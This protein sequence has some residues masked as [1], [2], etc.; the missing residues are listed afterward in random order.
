MKFLPDKEINLGARDLLGAKPYVTTLSTIIENSETPFTIGL[1][2]GWGVGK[3]S[4]IKTIQDEYNNHND[5]EI[6]VFTYDAW[7]YSN[8]SFR[9][10]F[11]FEIKE[12]FKMDISDSFR[13]FYENRSEEIDHKLA[14][15]K[16][17][18]WW[19][20]TLFPLLLF[21]VLLFP[22]QTDLKIITSII[23]IV[24]TIV[25]TLLRE[26]FVQYKVTVSKQKV[27]AP[28]QFEKIFS[29]IIEKITNKPKDKWE[30]IKGFLEKRKKKIKKLV[31]VIDN[32]DR[33]HK[34]LAFELLL[35]IKNFLEQKGVVFIIP[36]DEEE[37]K[38]HIKK[39]G[40]N[41]NEFLRKLFNTTISIKHISEG[42]LFD[43]AKKLN[44]KYNLKFP[45]DVI[46][47]VAQQFSK[48]PR[49]IIQ[50]LN[51]LQ[52][53][54]LLSKN[55]ESENLIPKGSISENIPF[56]TKLL[57]M[58]EEWPNLYFLF[59]TKP[60]ILNNIC[61]NIKKNENDFNIDGYNL[62]VEQRNFLRRTNHI[63][64]NHVNYELFF[65]NKDLYK[66]IPD[67]TSKLIESNDYE[68]IIKQLGLG[69]INFD[70]LIELIDKKLEIALERE[71]LNT[72]VVNI[73][74]LIMSLS[75]NKNYKQLTKQYLYNNGK[76]LGS[77]KNII[78]S[79]SIENPIENIDNITILNFIKEYDDLS[80][81]IFDYLI[82]KLRKRNNNEQEI[83][84]FVEIFK[85]EP[86]KLKKIASKFS[87]LVIK[88]DSFI[89][90]LKHILNRKSSMKSLVT[91]DLINN[92][93]S[94][95]KENDDV[96]LALKTPLIVKYHEMIGLNKSQLNETI[97]NLLTF[98]NARNDYTIQSRFKLLLTFIP[99]VEDSEL[100]TKIYNTINAKHNWL[101][102]QYSS[103]WNIEEFQVT[104]K[105]LLN[106]ISE[107]YLKTD[108]ATEEDNLINWLNY[109][110]NMN[111]SQELIIFINN[112][113]C[114]IIDSLKVYDWSYSNN[115]ITKFVQINEWETKQN[116]AKTL[117]LMLEKTTKE[118]GL[119]KQQIEEIYQIY[120]DIVTEKNLGLIIDWIQKSLENNHL[121]EYFED[122]ITTQNNEKK[123]ELL[124][125][126]NLLNKHK[127]IENIIYN[128]IIDIECDDI[129]EFFNYLQTNKV[130]K[131]III[132]SIKTI[133]KNTDRETTNFKC[134]IEYISKSKFADNATKNIIAEKIKNQLASA[135][136]TEIIFAL[137][138][139]E[140][141]TV[142]DSKKLNA[143]NTLI[144]D[145]NETNFSDSDKSFVKKMKKKYI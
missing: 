20:F 3:S 85:D 49:K 57:I 66:N 130:K 89:L 65:I 2:G 35:T 139:L 34:D 27:F 90:K 119:S 101:A 47:I 108:D 42:D 109:Y 24:L 135:N 113:Y 56:L 17:S 37:L 11:L 122:V 110:F 18:L 79:D 13:S 138:I 48:S 124:K 129:D 68:E 67:N 95:I 52:T 123:L 61:K 91:T 87:S 32:I 78:M 86:K 74:S 120:I 100:L 9:R 98:L 107:L 30:W 12:F 33:C 21:L 73:L 137:S 92:F 115:I 84:D 93:I 133:L 7:K 143:I 97:D 31:I 128:K 121:N 62:S 45:I 40:N 127:I 112:L 131:S 16:Y 70:T 81:H 88:N 29:E 102:Q 51:V 10:T 1:L 126:F 140:N 134:I 145:I 53:E 5:S 46:S 80:K 111:E 58:R 36:I 19:W 142:T 23:S 39:Q 69:Q 76:F 82:G 59:Q 144:Q 54:I 72:T 55:Q 8:D 83:I 15:K 117:N 103:Q 106:N 136:N 50:F 96:S 38:K 125:L 63:Q 141:L 43:F 71:E 116:I 114:N 22:I 105:L 14:V 132:K 118:N 99:N 60:F 77:F 41:P 4:I 44:D 64:P 6:A 94:N 26:T 104:L 28:E 25:T 75:I